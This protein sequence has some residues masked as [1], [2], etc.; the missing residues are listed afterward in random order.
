MKLTSEQIELINAFLVKNEVIF[1]DIRYEI[2]DHIATDVEENYAEIPFPEAIKI[3]LKKWESEVR[4]S[5]SFWINSWASFP[6]ISINKL[7]KLFLP[8]IIVICFILVANMIL[9]LYFQTFIEDLKV[10]ENPFKIVYILW[11]TVVSIFGIKLF[12]TKRYT[13]YKYVFKRNFYHIYLFTIL[14][15]FVS[16][17][18]IFM[19]SY[20]MINLS[21]TVFFV[22]NYK[23]HFK[24]IKQI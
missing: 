12:F 1:D 6:R 8:Q 15:F 13:T 2:I 17:I 11:F 19:V 10:Y 3:V 14:V 20:L 22:Q 18:D 4:M 16:T 9:N 24:F 5:S 23:A 7:K 21:F